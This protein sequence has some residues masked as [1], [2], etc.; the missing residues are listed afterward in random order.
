MKARWKMTTPHQPILLDLPGTGLRQGD[1]GKKLPVVEI[2]GPVVQGEGSMIGRRTT[3]VRFGL[4]DYRCSWCDSLYAVDP[5]LV[6]RDARKMTQ[7]EIAEEVLARTQDFEW[8]TFSGGNPLVHDVSHLVHRLVEGGRQIQVE[9]QGTLY[10]PWINEVHNIT[11]SPKPPSS[12]MVTDWKVLT[13]FLMRL[14]LDPILKVVVF[15]E[16]DFQFARD[17]HRHYPPMP[18]YLSVGNDLNRPDPNTTMD[19][20]DR[21]QWLVER[22]LR[23]PDM[24]DVTVLPQLHVL[25]YQNQRGK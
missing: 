11:V 24:Y 16:D 7:T 19:L 1:P 23:E 10:R 14:T 20:L 15:D 9:T 4:C 18:L 17:V 2:F 6:N 12:G 8:V 3:F 25:L 22:T 5:V 21:L 13:N